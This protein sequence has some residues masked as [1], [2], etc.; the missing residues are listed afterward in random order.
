MNAGES[1]GGKRSGFCLPFCFEVWEGDW[2]DDG[3]GGKS[4]RVG[5][6]VNWDV[7]D[8]DWVKTFVG[9]WE[10]RSIRHPLIAA[11]KRDLGHGFCRLVPG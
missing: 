10:S 4:G 6:Y 8:E 11:L 7:W 1:E 3:R 5:S 2:R 9:W